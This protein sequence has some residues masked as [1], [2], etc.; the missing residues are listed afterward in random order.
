MIS[1]SK[2][3]ATPRRFRSGYTQRMLR[4]TRHCDRLLTL[5]DA[6]LRTLLAR[7]PAA[8]PS[9]AAAEPDAPLSSTQ[10]E[11]SSALM[12]VNHAGEIGAQALYTGQALLAQS[13]TTRQHLLEAAAEEHDHLAWCAERL[14]ELGGRRSWLDPVWYLGGLGIGVL[15]ATTGDRVSLGFIVET[16]R[17]VE[18]HLD[19]HLARLPDQD[20]KSRAVLRQMAADE[21]RHGS[22]AEHAGGVELPYP[23][24]RLMGLG[25]E[26]LRRIAFFL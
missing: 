10:R 18:A 4:S 14:D 13:T 25:G 12:R 7:A 9:P 11:T 15:A 24:R 23:V 6:S 8:R 3:A 17:Q 19:D 21:A 1:I 20:L 22:A 16:E 26:I 5:L 2:N